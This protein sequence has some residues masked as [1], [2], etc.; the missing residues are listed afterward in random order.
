[1]APQDRPTVLLIDPDHLEAARLR[2]LLS[3]RY[4][5]EAV[6]DAAAAHAWRA[7]TERPPTLVV[8]ELELPD[9]DGLILCADLR[10]RTAAALLVHTS[11]DSRRDLVLSLRL[12]ADDFVVKPA[13]PSELEARIGAL[14][15]RAAR[16]VSSGAATRSA[17][18]PRDPAGV[19]RIGDLVIDR[20][21]A[22]ATIGDRRLALTQTEFRLLSAFAR[23]LDEALPRQELARQAG[24]DAYVAGTRA[25]DMHVRRLR[26]KLHA[27]LEVATTHT[28][29][30][31]TA[32]G[33]R[34]P[35]IVPVRGLGYR[36]TSP[37]A[38]PRRRIAPPAA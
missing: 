11:R 13:D 18:A 24:D 20:E 28:D 34:L 3:L 26:A 10:S 14:M 32:P 12:G 23:H 1:M 33:S 4:T 17:S 27:A 21:R 30:A 5:V 19:Q 8:L 6:P 25:L 35:A 38:A 2:H 31:Q 36:M 29:P 16:S 7:T 22:T 15:R 9:V 37:L